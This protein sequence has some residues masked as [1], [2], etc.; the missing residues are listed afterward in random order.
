MRA[1]GIRSA[2][3][4]SAVGLSSSE[5]I[6]NEYMK[7]VQN[8][9][10]RTT[11]PKDVAIIGAGIAGLVS[12]SL[13]ANARH[14]V[15]I[16]EA[17][18]RI[19][20]RILTV[21]EPFSNGLYGEAGAMRLPK[22]YQLTL[23]YVKQFKLPTNTFYNH[24]VPNVNEKPNENGVNEYIFVNGVKKRRSDYETNPDLKYPLDP[25]EEGYTAEKLL[26][27]ALRP[28]AKYVLEEPVERWQYN[29]WKPVIERFGEYS[30]R[31]Y[32]KKQTFYSEAAIE[33]IEVLMGLESRSNQ[34]LIQQIVEINDHGSD[35]EYQEITGGMDK[36]PLK[37]SEELE[38]LKV[39]IHFNHRLTGITQKEK[40]P[41]TLY[42]E[43]DSSNNSSSNEKFQSESQTDAVIV[44]VPFPG[45]RYVKMD[46]LLS[47]NK[48]KAIR[49]LHY[50]AATKI[51]LEF[52]SRF[53][54]TVDGIYGG[55]TI[56]DLPSR[57]IYYPC[58][59]WHDDGGGVVICSYTWGD[60]ARGWDALSKEDQI[61][62]V[63]DD[64]ELIHGSCVHEEYVRGSGVV[65][66]W[67]TD[68]YSY[69]EAAMF[70]GGQLE[71]LQTYIPKQEGNIHFAGEHTSL[72]HAWIEGAIES[73]IRVALEINK[74]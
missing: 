3:G 10:P 60:E 9:L 44:T 72:K 42:F 65:Q 15:T 53:W 38:K 29:R 23:E 59:G 63:L 16:F 6:E 56:T 74:K 22:F 28:I 26:E 43:P 21:R 1:L 31:E 35:V 8:G 30:V 57:F 67:A 14:N 66:S 58:H 34:S 52:K 41:V 20:G 18:N 25:I 11:N 68:R 50:D 17:S 4:L 54:E 5:E 64:M 73:G 19:G 61:S 2:V 49:E 55:C 27:F 51:L 48:R 71:E 37:F 13:L 12:A 46:P 45:L 70:Y 24:D 32:L 62:N 7:I 39:N 36:L 33:M 69:G 47:H 40:K